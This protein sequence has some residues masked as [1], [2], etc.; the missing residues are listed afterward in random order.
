M[1]AA[2]RSTAKPEVPAGTLAGPAALGPGPRRERLARP[3]RRLPEGSQ[4]RLEAQPGH[5]PRRRRPSGGGGG[6][7]G[8]YGG[9]SGGGLNG[10]TGGNGG[11][12]GSS[13]VP[14]GGSATSGT[15]DTPGGVTISFT[16]GPV[17]AP[18]QS[19]AMLRRWNNTDVTVTWN[20]TAAD[21]NSIDP[22]DCRTSSTS[23]GEGSIPLSGDVL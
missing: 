17:A 13:L 12:G 8:Y 5:R 16:A 20:W 7:G 11:G 10:D 18:T 22:T 19:P 3:A 9:G 21:P 15:A 6:G 14:P 23:S 1:L 2:G 4:V